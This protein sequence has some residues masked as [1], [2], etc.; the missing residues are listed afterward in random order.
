MSVSAK[1]TNIASVSVPDTLE[2][3]REFQRG[4]TL[5]LTHSVTATRARL[6]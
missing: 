2:T 3:L 4:Q 5:P 6:R 1:H